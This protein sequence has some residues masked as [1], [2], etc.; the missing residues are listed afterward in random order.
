MLAKSECGISDWIGMALMSGLSFGAAVV[1]LLAGAALCRY[2]LA[3]RRE[4]AK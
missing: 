3:G 2:L 1:L 4:V